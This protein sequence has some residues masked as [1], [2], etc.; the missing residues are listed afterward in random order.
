VRIP[1]GQHLPF[2]PFDGKAFRLRIGARPLDPSAW[3]VL[4]ERTDSE[5]DHKVA[6]L[7][8]SP[9]QFAACVALPEDSLS[10]AAA[11]ELCDAVENHLH[12]HEPDHW[13]DANNRV[14]R[15]E[16]ANPGHSPAP[17]LVKAGLLTQEDWCILTQQPAKE[18]VL[19]LAG[20]SSASLRAPKQGSLPADK[21]DREPLLLTAGILCFPN[22]WRLSE[23]IGLPMLGIHTPVSQYGEEIGAPTDSLLDRLKPGH[24][25]WRMNWG[26][27]DNPTLH[28]PTGHFD[29]NA[30]TRVLDIGNDVVLR[31]ERQTLIRLPKTGAVVFGIR[32]IVRTLNEVL[33][34]DPTVASRMA[35]ALDTLP[36]DMRAY[37]SLT[38]LGPT[39]SAWLREQ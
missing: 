17:D 24:P 31:I 10:I 30:G 23:K 22:R 21:P 11:A 6:L 29:P 38:K 13:H 8:E 7:A 18:A 32:T 3:I 28:Q 39:V 33:F 16:S 15:F 27:A 19:E 34:S 5:L 14:N 37:K 26:I 12:T 2:D 1:D 9:E 25:V 4:D 35:T 20:S 36:D